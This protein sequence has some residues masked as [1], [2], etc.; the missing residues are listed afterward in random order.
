[1][2]AKQDS[3]DKISEIEQRIEKVTS[4]SDT[5]KLEKS[6]F[7]N[8]ASASKVITDMIAGVLVGGFLG[9]LLDN[10]LST[11]PIYIFLFSVLG[12]AGSMFNLYKSIK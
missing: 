8:R 9:Y 12:F 11:F 7:D 6:T 10:Y 1:M 5:Q 4:L 2:K 3:K